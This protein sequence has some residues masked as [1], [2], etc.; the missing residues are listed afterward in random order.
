V[1][2]LYTYFRS[3]AAYRVRIT[4]NLKGVAYQ[5]E[6][7][8]LLRG[9][10]EQ[11]QPAY[12]KL[13]PQGLVPTLVDGEEVIT[14][15]L[16]IIAYLDEVY[17]QS[18]LLPTDLKARAYVRSLA[19]TVACDIHP[20]NNL[21]VRQYLGEHLG[22]SD[23]DWQNWYDHWIQEGFK[24]FEAALTSH[25]STGQCCY[26]DSPTLA[27]ICLIPQVFNALRFNCDLS[28]YPLLQ[29][30]YRYCLSLE[31]FWQAAPERQA[32]SLEA[33]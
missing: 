16:A 33:S 12:L 13:N 11:R 14:Q 7:I 10:G 32:D 26:G 22:C 9:G 3:S 18:P 23:A 8:H 1:L 19:Q 5:P 31:A 29:R 28:P 20:L 30:I 2:T 17:P 27:D 25:P 21:R 6:F 4:L 24:A 15:S